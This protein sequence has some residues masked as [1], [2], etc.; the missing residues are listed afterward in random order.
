[1]AITEAE[2]HAIARAHIDRVCV[3]VPDG[4]AIVP[5]VTLRKAYGWVFFYESLE[6]LRTGDPLLA[7]GGNGPVVVDLDG[8]VHQ[9]GTGR[10]LEA[11]LADLEARY[12]S[13]PR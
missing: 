5:E 11:M 9:L 10:A 2:A 12:P 13:P 1:M 4:V 8:E 3:D 7:L 6:H